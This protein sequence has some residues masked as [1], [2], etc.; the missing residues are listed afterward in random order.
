MRA[1]FHFFPVLKYRSYRVDGSMGDLIKVILTGIWKKGRCKMKWLDGYRMRLLLVGFV[2]AI[3]LSGGGSAKADFIFGEPTNLGPTVNSSSGDAVDCFSADG[4]E[5]YFDSRR[6]GGHGD[7][8]IWVARRPTTDDDWGT[9]E[10]VGSPVNTGRAEAVAH[11]SADGLEL[12]FGSYNAPGGYG[13]YDI[14]VTKRATK[15]DSWGPPVNLGP[16]INGSS[17]DG[18]FC[19]SADGLEL[20]FSSR[21]SGGYGSDDIWVTS[22]ATVNDPW[23]APVN[24]GPVVNSSASE[25]FPSFSS[26]GLLLFFSEEYGSPIRPGGF[27]NVDMWVTRRA[28]VSEPWG[29][30]VNLGPMVNS[31]SL[32]AGPRISPDGYMLY[33]S[34]ERPGG[35]GGPFG[36]I[37]QA[38]IIPIV[39]FNG[40]GIVDSADMCIMVDHW[41]ENY[42]LCDI[43]PT[44]LGDGIV[45]VE[46]LKVLSENLFE[47]I[48]DPTLVAH[49][50]LDE[51]EG[52]VVADSAGDNNGYALGDPVWQPD[53]GIVDGALQLDGV[54]DYVITG[55][56]L[57]P[58]EGPF[59]VLAWI[60]GGAPGQVVISQQGAANWLTA[61]AEGNVMTELKSSGRSATP[62]LSETN[63]TDGN[64]HRIGLTW[65]GSN[66]TLYVD[67]V[68]VAEDEQTN[69]ASSEN[70]LYIG[71]GN[72]MQPG[73][74]FSGLIDDVRIYNRVVNP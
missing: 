31:P 42:S 49:W 9:T 69:L 67:G 62:L 32:D 8:D 26:D 55:T 30:P 71:T 61:D 28:S 63:I 6:S 52:M 54:D 59:S 29:T 21:R 70:G 57:N 11:I 45:D 36:D 72:A 2:A 10:N 40:D 5:M 34:S 65:D 7:W 33:F 16:A 56:A 38:P 27:G 25:C 19:L 20:Y 60:K 68:A 43:G 17:R 39:D 12:Y 35:L 53:A 1:V 66:R 24:L 73:T 51:T 64:W 14:W 22:R 46:D 37:Y 4:L 13:E 44:P 41:G 48:N 15:E 50:A 58:A 18:A 23:E 3:V 74:Y 47:D